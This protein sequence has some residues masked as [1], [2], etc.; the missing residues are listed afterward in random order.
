MQEAILT[1]LVKEMEISDIRVK[2]ERKHTCY[3][4]MYGIRI[5]ATV[6]TEGLAHLELL[7]SNGIFFLLW[8]LWLNILQILT[9]NE[10]IGL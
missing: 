7:K 9:L 3:L 5:F 8:Y 4:L 2:L 1:G 6:S 10:S